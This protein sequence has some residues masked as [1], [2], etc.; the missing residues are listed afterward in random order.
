MQVKSLSESRAA[1]KTFRPTNFAKANYD[2]PAGSKD[3]QSADPQ[4]EP[5]LA[6]IIFSNVTSSSSS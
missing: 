5:I 4:S 6:I 3:V 1:G 2:H